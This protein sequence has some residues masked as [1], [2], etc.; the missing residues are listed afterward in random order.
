[1]IQLLSGAI[2]MGYWVAGLYFFRFWRRSRDRLFAVFGAAF[3]LLGVQRLALATR[4]EWNAEY[5]TIYLLRLLA[6]LMILA[7]IIDKNRAGAAA[8][9]GRPRR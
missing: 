4:P 3:W 8:S 5:G 7:A 2:V 1:M 9:A 6:F